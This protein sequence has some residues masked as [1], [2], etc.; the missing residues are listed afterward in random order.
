MRAKKRVGSNT[1]SCQGVTPLGR[2]LIGVIPLARTLLYTIGSDC[3][4][5]LP[6]IVH[7]PNLIIYINSPKHED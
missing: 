5:H 2:K 1:M 7:I 4:V 3:S 6:M